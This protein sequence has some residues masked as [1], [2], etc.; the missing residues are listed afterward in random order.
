M[1]RQLRHR[2]LVDWLPSPVSATFRQFGLP[3]FGGSGLRTRRILRQTRQAHAHP[4]REIGDHTIGQLVGPFRHLQVRILMADCLQQQA[5]VRR[6]RIHQRTTL[7]AL[8]KTTAKVQPQ[9][10][11]GLLRAVA[12]VAV[13]HQH[14]PDA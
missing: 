5:L 3:F 2:W 7:A 11:L 8:F 12:F 4:A 14:R 6:T 10:A 13:H 1:R 9:A